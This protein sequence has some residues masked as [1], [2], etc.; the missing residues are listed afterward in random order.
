[1]RSLPVLPKLSL[2]FKKKCACYSL[3]TIRGKYISEKGLS[4]SG[5]VVLMS[6]H[7]GLQLLCHLTS[8]LFYK[9]GH[10]IHSYTKTPMCTPVTSTTHIPGYLHAHSG[11]SE[12]EKHAIPPNAYLTDSG[13]RMHTHGAIYHALPHMKQTS[14]ETSDTMQYVLHRILSTWLEELYISWKLT[15]T[16]L[17]K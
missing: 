4:D 11:H 6:G 2:L 15:G 16:L 13:C 17:D 12:L 7:F 8:Q 9:K 10:S 5:L 14:S 3:N 1:M